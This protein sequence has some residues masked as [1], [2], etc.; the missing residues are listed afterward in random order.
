MKFC[1]GQT[2][3][4]YNVFMEVNNDHMKAHADATHSLIA[5]AI[6][7]I[8]YTPTF[9]MN[10]IDMGRIIG[11]DACVEVN[12]HDDVREICRPGRTLPSRIVF[13]KQPMDTCYFTIGMCTDND[14]LVTIFT[15]FPG[16]KA[17]KET[18]DPNLK[19]YER[20]ESERFWSTHALCNQ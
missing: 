13:N 19:D 3:N 2:A 15:A 14:G 17:P 11:K 10:S 20:E 12:E 1:I 8:E 7:K 9:W 18:N 4:G 5:E 16:M 6:Q